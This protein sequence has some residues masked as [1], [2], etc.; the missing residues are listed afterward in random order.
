MAADP[1]SAAFGLPERGGSVVREVRGGF[2]TLFAM[3]YIVVLNP[4]ILGGGKDAYGHSF[5]VT[6]VPDAART[7]VIG[8][9]VIA[10]VAIKLVPGR[11]RE[12]HLL[13]VVIALL[14]VVYF[15]I[16]PIERWLGVR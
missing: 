15:A 1:V 9:A 14:F 16:G 10:F 8:A 12:V 4:L 7:T 3:A 5:F 6:R 2:A 11:L 13:M